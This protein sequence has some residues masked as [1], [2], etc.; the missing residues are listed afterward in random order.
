MAVIR[1][2]T[3]TVQEVAT[4]DGPMTTAAGSRQYGLKDSTVIGATLIPGADTYFY[5]TPSGGLQEVSPQA[6]G[7]ASPVLL[8]APAGFGYVVPFSVY[9]S[10]TT[11][12]TN[13]SMAAAKPTPTVTIYCGPGG[14]NTAAG[15]S[16]ATRVRSLKQAMVRANA[17]AASAIVRVLA[18]AGSYFYSNQDGTSIPDSFN[19]QTCTRAG[20]IIE[21]CDSNG[22]VLTDSSYIAS[23]QN[24]VMPAFVAT[25]DA[26]IYV[27]TYTTEVP[28]RGVWDAAFLNVD[29]NPQ[30]LRYASGG[31]DGNTATIFAAI[32]A[33][34][35][36]GHGAHYLD[37]TNKKLYVRLKDNRAPDANLYVGRGNV[38]NGDA[39]TRNFYLS[40]RF[41]NTNTVWMR[42]VRLYGGVPLYCSGYVPDGQNPQVYLSGVHAC[43]SMLNNIS[44]D[45]QYTATLENCVSG[46]A[47]KDGYNYDQSSGLDPSAVA[48]SR[49]HEINCKGDWNGNDN[50]TGQSS[51]NLS[52]AHMRLRGV[53]V[54]TT[55]EK[56]Q[57]I[58]I[59]DI[60]AAKTWNL[61]C[62]PSNGQQTGIA[63]PAFCSG[64]YSA[65]AGTET[66]EMWLDGC[67]S[68]GNDYDLGT[69]KGGKLYYTNMVIGD[70]KLSYGG[71]ATN[72]IQPYTDSLPLEYSAVFDDDFATLNRSVWSPALRGGADPKGFSPGPEYQFNV[73]PD[74][75]GWAGFTPFSISDGL[76]ISAT[77][78][79]TVPGLAGG[80]VPNDPKTSAPYSWL[81]GYIQSSGAV[82]FRSGVVDFW[83]EGVTFATAMWPAAWM[84]PLVGEV[85][86][87]FPEIDVMELIGNAPTQNNFNVITA[88]GQNAFQFV[89]ATSQFVGA[90][91][92]RCIITDTAIEFYYDGQLKFTVDITN[93]PEVQAELYLILNL[94]FGSNL[95]GGWVPPPTGAEASPQQFKF[96][97]TRVSR[98]PGPDSLDMSNVAVLDT[99]TP[100]PIGTLSSTAYG[101]SPSPAYSVLAGGSGHV[102]VAGAALSWSQAKVAGTYA[103]KVRVTDSNGKKWDRRFNLQVVTDNIGTN[104]LTAPTDL[105]NAA[106]NKYG[107]T[108]IGGQTDMAGGTT[109]QRIQES[110][111]SPGVPEHHSL[112]RF[113]TKPASSLPYTLAMDLAYDGST[114][115]VRLEMDNGYAAPVWAYMNLLTG[116]FG[117]AF[118]SDAAQLSLLSRSMVNLGGI[119]R[120]VQLRSQV[121][122]SV[123]NLRVG[124]KQVLNGADYGQHVGNTAN[125]IRARTKMQLVQV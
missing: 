2:S 56:S 45:G 89:K 104:L 82:T 52:S 7:G 17:Q 3:G 107:V 105:T 26:N 85:V 99:N 22:N 28:N 91:W 83:V 61:G 11:Y 29:G 60:S 120:R 109:A 72:T 19:S 5:L 117:D 23:I 27:S 102:S 110:I 32:N 115:W 49:F 63:I 39:N 111:S 21:P 97:R 86:G 113:Y 78:T 10:G 6:G 37:V 58:A 54:N 33:R 34:A 15:T 121:A 75:A 48:V 68:P 38:G 50:N 81:S 116:E 25:A 65:T 88:A 66:T 9:R 55:G 12:S 59:A 123:T 80:Q 13:F 46:D 74:H 4:E 24:Q 92:Y 20:L 18:Q 122:A 35:S 62:A 47:Y 103:E 36:I 98:K 79:S 100:G 125:G 64:F 40:G 108:I 1:T 114:Q 69:D 96:K 43:Y 53:R 77:K 14:D 124:V 119:W 94:A 8:A 70:F 90:G 93:K 112:E 71:G 101:S 44:F 57:N 42:N 73:N 16:W 67:S 106:W 95:G 118:P 84:R 87:V 31:A 30:S 51:S 41:G 76:V